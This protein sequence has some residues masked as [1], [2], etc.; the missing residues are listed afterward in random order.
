MTPAQRDE[1][2]MLRGRASLALVGLEDGVVRHRLLRFLQES[3]PVPAEIAHTPV[4]APLVGARGET[5]DLPLQERDEQC[6]HLDPLPEG[7]GT[8]RRDAGTPGKSGRNETTALVRRDRRSHGR[9]FAPEVRE[10][11]L[12][13]VAAGRKPAD[14]ARILR[15]EMRD[16]APHRDT[17]RNWAR[18]ERLPLKL[19]NSRLTGAMRDRMYELF[20]QGIVGQAAYA[21]L[22]KEFGP[23]PI[24][25]GTLGWHKA[26]TWPGRNGSAQPA[27]VGQAFQ[28]VTAQAGKPALRGEG[29]DQQDQ[30][31]SDPRHVDSPRGKDKKPTAEEIAFVKEQLRNG[32][33][34]TAIVEMMVEEFGPER[35]FH[36]VTIYGWKKKWAEA[37]AAILPGPPDESEKRKNLSPG[38]AEAVTASNNPKQVVTTGALALILGWGDAQVDQAANLGNWPR[39]DG[40]LVVDGLPEGIRR[41][42]VAALAKE[43]A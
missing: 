5:Q 14:V 37:S 27:P 16:D 39:E 7:V 22:E 18:N 28:P 25:V 11:A 29:N 2:M 4:G 31:N 35:R 12:A 21:A 32:V 33:S 6:S 1:L 9:R 20:D 23:L 42:V 40:R 41:K 17:V 15:D 19:A 26:M 8:D 34:P 38:G 10:R 43:A 36:P 24:R 13:L 30:P 3:D